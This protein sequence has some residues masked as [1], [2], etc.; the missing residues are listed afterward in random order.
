MRKKLFG[1]WIHLVLVMTH[2]SRWIFHLIEHDPLSRKIEY[3]MVLV[4]C[5]N[6]N[7]H[8]SHKPLTV[9]AVSVQ[10][11]SSRQFPKRQQ[12]IMTSFLWA[13]HCFYLPLR[14]LMGT[15]AIPWKCCCHTGGAGRDSDESYYLLKLLPRSD[16]FP[17]TYHWPK[18]VTWPYLTFC[19]LKRTKIR[20]A[21]VWG[22]SSGTFGAGRCGSCF[23]HLFCG[24]QHLSSYFFGCFP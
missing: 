16:L 22:Q 14:S 11:C 7:V 15:P 6:S 1:N 17:S 3:L 13:F 20:Y 8:T 12:K 9:Q 18:Q 19:Y 21:Q 24:P 4:K 23:A 10:R 5:K 2:L